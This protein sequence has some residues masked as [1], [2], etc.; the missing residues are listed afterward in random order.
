MTGKHFIL[1]CLSIL[2][3]DIFYLIAGTHAVALRLPRLLRANR[4]MAFSSKTETRTRY[5]NLLRIFA[6]VV[7]VLLIF[8]WNACFYFAI[9]ASIGLGSDKWVYPDRSGPGSQHTVSHQYLFSLYWSARMLTTGESEN[10]PETNSELL[11]VLFDL[12]VGFLVFAAIV[13][14]FG[15]IIIHMM[16]SRREFLDQAEA[17]KRYM[18]FHGV[19]ED[20]HTRVV[21]LLDYMWS[22]KQSFGQH[23][24]LR[25]LPDNLRAEIAVNV[26]LAALKRVQVF[27][28]CDPGFLKELVLKLRSQVFSPGDY[29]CRKGEMGREMYI[30]KSGRLE[31][32]G[33]SGIGVIATLNEGSYLGEISILNMTGTGNRRTANVRSIGFSDLLSLSKEDLL[34]VLKEYP[35]ARKKL[36]TRGRRLLRRSR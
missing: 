23:E 35:D 11:F 24:V 25:R 8:H 3:L 4:V 12:T 15:G 34:E 32:V 2:P 20:L 31:V 1:D 27:S 33:D 16:H 13:G 17:I 19:G 9:S 14:Q 22:T 18:E 10:P 36:E 6:L 30:V 7:A 5:P 21:G 28:D 29:V 26:H